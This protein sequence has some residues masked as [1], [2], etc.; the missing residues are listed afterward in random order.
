MKYDN[1]EKGTPSPL[2]PLSSVVEDVVPI[3]VVEVESIKN[4]NTGQ[5]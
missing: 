4:I 5:N 1:N 3:L 2:P